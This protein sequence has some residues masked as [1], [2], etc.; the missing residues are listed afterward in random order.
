MQEGPSLRIVVV[1]GSLSGL[2]AGIALARAGHEVRVLERAIAQPGGAGVGVDLAL[3]QEITGADAGTL[4]VVRGN[5]YSSSWYLVRQ[6]LLDVALQTPGLDILEGVEATSFTVNGVTVVVQTTEL[7]QEADM[8]V[9]ADGYKSRVRAFVDPKHHDAMYA[10]Y[11]LWRGMCG[12]EQMPSTTPW[13]DGYVDVHT[14]QRYRLVAYAVPGPDG[15]LDPGRRQISWA[16]YDPD[17]RGFLEDR[18]CLAGDRVIGTLSGDGFGQALISE[19][20]SKAER[21]WP[22]PWREAIET[23]LRNGEPFATPV[24]EYVPNRLASNRALIVGD[25]AHVASPMT[26]SGFRYALL[27]VLA[28]CRAL[29]ANPD[30]AMALRA[31]EQERLE[32]DRQLVLAGHAWGQRYLTSD[33][34]RYSQI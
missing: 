4:P 25:A 6:W 29:R 22:S 16:W 32:D 34:S 9:G 31:F 27:D 1:G 23:T 5:R 7:P 20:V 18:D 13:P 14:T 33:D 11:M 28:I 8:L 17:R 21:L 26:G 12:E 30:V 10:G 15:S 19:L 2:S 24:A 3:L